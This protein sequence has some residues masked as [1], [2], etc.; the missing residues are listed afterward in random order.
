MGPDRIVERLASLN[1]RQAVWLFPIAYTLHVLEELP[2]FT[3]WARRYASPAFTMRDY[4]VIHMT[5]IVVAFVAP[6]VINRFPH[7][8]IFGFFAFI[9]T[10]AVCFNILFHTGATVAFGAYSP[11]LLT[12]VTLYPPVLYMVS[13]QALR[14]G[15]LG[16][17]RQSFLSRWLV[18]FMQPTYRT[19][20]SRFGDGEIVVEER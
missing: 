19:T 2:L 3:S 13:R 20:S 10:P 17:W 18:Y 1:F 8:A 7:R 6:L 14:E 4:L 12:A 11:G 9:F 16:N 5:G 15:L